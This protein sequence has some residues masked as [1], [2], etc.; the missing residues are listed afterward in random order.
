M[1]TERENN[2][3]FGRALFRVAGVVAR[4]MYSTMELSL[5]FALIVRMYI[6]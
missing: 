6:S 3:N 5:V 4:W 1:A 2:F